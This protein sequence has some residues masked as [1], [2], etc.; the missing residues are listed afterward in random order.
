MLLL[1]HFYNTVIAGADL[2][3]LRFCLLT[4]LLVSLNVMA[5]PRYSDPDGCLS[6]H[7]Y[8]GLDYI[9][10]EG[11]LRSATIDRSHYASSLHGSVP[12][13]DCH[14]NTV[15]Y[16]HK[17]ENTEVDCSES[18]HVEEP[19][20]G[21]KY[22]HDVIHDEMD[23][24]VHAGGWYK[25]LTGG[26][27]LEEIET[28]QD[29]SCRR[30][31]SN[32]LY[33]AETQLENF[34]EAFDHAETECGNCHQ[35]KAW[36]GQFGGHILRRLVGRRWNN[37]ENN[38]MCVDCHGDI[39]KMRDVEQEDPET[40]EKHPASDRFVHSA[41]SY[42]KTL[43]GRLIVDGSDY[44]ASCIDC[45]A[46]EGWK[47]EIRSYLDPLSASHIDNLPE[48]CGQSNCHTYSKKAI[49]S[50]FTET[51]MHDLSLLGLT[52]FENP[53]VDD[54]LFKSAWFWSSWP[55]LLIG[56]VFIIG[57]IIWWVFYRTTKK[58]IPILGGNRFE[59]I[60][61]GRKP[62]AARKNPVAK[63]TTKPVAEEAENK[64][65]QADNGPDEKG[66]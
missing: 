15:D 1:V 56:L 60:M 18:C 45:H 22:S 57:S 31:H 17:V 61:I 19:S 4:L 42:A 44:G 52:K 62:R 24:S 32:T 28:E 54:G 65:R 29:P 2:N 41:D 11:V 30:C 25:G 3:M 38:Q 34:K 39:E 26:N 33:I 37:Q 14:R 10:T 64:T 46:P 27:R 66:A 49:N 40:L 9:D 35:G 53:F 55:L 50:G 47:H 7:A 13:K 21:V 6:C 51:D 59:R 16:P 43:H 8:Q 58:I 20:E 63:K 36:M 5:N 48:S 12:C 23:K